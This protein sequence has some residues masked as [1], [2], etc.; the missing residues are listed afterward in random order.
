[1]YPRFFGPAIYRGSYCAASLGVATEEDNK[2]VSSVICK[3][4]CGPSPSPAKGL[5]TP[6]AH[7]SVPT[8]PVVSELSYRKYEDIAQDESESSF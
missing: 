2:K 6:S 1:M 3:R 7:I 4:S 5:R 8:S